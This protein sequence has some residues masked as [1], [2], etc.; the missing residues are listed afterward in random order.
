MQAL[1]YEQFD[2]I[3]R[4]FE[5]E[6]METASVPVVS[7]SVESVGSTDSQN[8]QS[9]PDMEQRYSNFTGLLLS[10]ICGTEILCLQ[11]YD[12][13]ISTFAKFSPE[14]TSSFIH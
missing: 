14:K 6:K 5:K 4:A 2:D 1:K 7:D 8:T 13:Q 11:C 9:N 10:Y 3:H 12:S